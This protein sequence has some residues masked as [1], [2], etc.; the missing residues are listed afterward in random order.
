[1]PVPEY[2]IRPGVVDTANEQPGSRAPYQQHP[3]AKACQLSL[4]GTHA[5][6]VTDA[7][8][9]LWRCPT[10]AFARRACPERDDVNEAANDA[11]REVTN[12]VP[13]EDTDVDRD[14]DIR[15]A[16]RGSEGEKQRQQRSPYKEHYSNAVV[17]PTPPAPSARCRTTC[18]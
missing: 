2:S 14:A 17:N 5:K 15:E 3:Y 18:R 1:M 11:A 8:R 7:S 9:R 12:E 13:H 6:H 16:D 10:S 4:L